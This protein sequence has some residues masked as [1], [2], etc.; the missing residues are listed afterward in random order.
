MSERVS[1][2]VHTSVIAHSVFVFACRQAQSRRALPHLSLSS[3]HPSDSDAHLER[4]QHR[5][6]R[7]LRRRIEDLEA[8][9]SGRS[10]RSEAEG[11]ASLAPAADDKSTQHNVTRLPRVAFVMADTDQGTAHKTAALPFVPGPEK[12]PSSCPGAASDNLSG[13]RRLGRRGVVRHRSSDGGAAGRGEPS[14]CVDPVTATATT[15]RKRSKRVVSDGVT[16]ADPSSGTATAAATATAMAAPAAAKTAGVGA[17]ASTAIAAGPVEH[18]GLESG[19]PTSARQRQAYYR[20]LDDHRSTQE[21]L[22]EVV[23]ELQRWH[24]VPTGQSNL[25][26]SLSRRASAASRKSGDPSALLW[27][28]RAELQQRL[29]SISYRMMA[30]LDEDGGN[31]S[32]SAVVQPPSSFRHGLRSPPSTPAGLRTGQVR[33][34]FQPAPRSSSQPPVDDSPHPGLADPLVT[35][36]RTV[37]RW[38][39]CLLVLPDCVP[40]LH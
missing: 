18:L 35:Y 29:V 7:D 24:G 34:T 5:R 14:R 31:D 8:R 25:R 12:T 11:R 2:L 16:P 22:W 30:P 40:H 38:H 10:G 39:C 21:R 9:I 15:A 1:L 32:T 4:R 36:V 28:Q 19:G 20:L 23:D 27:E 33:L 3:K 6:R 13:A 37:R 17:A 26:V